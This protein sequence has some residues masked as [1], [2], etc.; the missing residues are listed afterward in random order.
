MQD[1]SLAPAEPGPLAGKIV[2]N[3]GQ[4]VVGCVIRRMSADGASIDVESSLGLPG[5]FNLVIA[6][7]RGSR[8][9]KVLWQTDK[10][11]EVAFENVP[12]GETI[13]ACGNVTAGDDGSVGHASELDKRSDPVRAHMLALRASLDEMDVGVVLLDSALRAQFINKAFRRIW[14]LP[15]DKADR[16]PTF[17]SL[18][19][20]GRDTNAYE[21]DVKNIDAY[22]EERIALVQAGSVK[23]LDLRRSNGSVLRM[24]VAVLP[25]GGRLIS[26]TDVTDIVKHSDEL[27][28]LQESLDKVDEGIAIFDGDL[29]ARFLNQR[30]RKFWD[31]T[32]ETVANRASLSDLMRAGPRSA[33]VG[34][35]PEER[36]AFFARRIASIKAGDA[37]P[38]DLHMTDGRHLR[39]RCTVLPNDG[40]MLIYSDVTDFVK[41]AQQLEKLANIDD[42][43]GLYNRRYFME[44]AKAEWSRFRRYD[45][46]LSLL[47]IDIDLFKT[48]ND[49][50]GHAVGDE[51]IKNVA[52]CL[53]NGRRMSDSVGRL[54]G[55]EFAILMPE[56]D[57]AAAGVVAERI[58]ESVAALDMT[59]HRAHYSLTISI[60]LVG[61][62]R[63]MSALDILF[64]TADDALYAAKSKGRNRCEVVTLADPPTREFPAES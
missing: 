42:M 35:A 15:D 14:K 64:K 22:V 4:S 20:H 60:G 31:V 41:N 17:A 43:T 13:A 6:S 21:V 34:M 62:T 12:V 56:T 58:R 63:A 59:A 37:T 47:L 48:V 2:F 29:R 11:I 26:Y 27:E 5:Q 61:A 23:P 3:F 16:N 18:M 8:P 40:R 9:C 30:V 45:R 10:Q 51:A 54:G 55:E 36:D 57:V 32:N 1:A 44:S 7:E 52:A 19:Q 28:L 53:L 46:P 39:A 33:T 24:Q 49:R 50:Y 38:L 25:D